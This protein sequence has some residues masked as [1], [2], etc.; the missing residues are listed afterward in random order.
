MDV[1]EM[2]GL[3]RKKQDKL[4]VDL[5]RVQKVVQAFGVV[6]EEIDGFS[7]YDVSR[8]PY[9]KEEILRSVLVAIRVNADSAIQKQLENGLVFLAQFQEGVGPDPIS[10]LPI[11]APAL[12]KAHQA[13]KISIQEM[14]S[15]VANASEAVDQ[16]KLAMLQ[17]KSE[18]ETEKY[19]RLIEHAKGA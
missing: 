7:F 19:L 18:Q 4:E 5:E 15:K 11:D 12:L 1:L 6:L 8:L 17:R 9:S 2:F 3:F 10:S 16:E 13:G 14:A